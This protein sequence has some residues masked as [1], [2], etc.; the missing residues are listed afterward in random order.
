MTKY[1]LIDVQLYCDI[2]YYMYFNFAL[3]NRREIIFEN[4]VKV[5]ERK[6]F[7]TKVKLTVGKITPKYIIYSKLRRRPVK[8]A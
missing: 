8:I 3:V 5:G 7:L 6:G 4:I 1:I 2:I